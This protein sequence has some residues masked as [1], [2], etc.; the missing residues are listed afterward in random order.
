MCVQL[1]DHFFMSV[2]W[3]AT[4]GFL[5][6][7]FWSPN[8]G[9]S[10]IL[11]GCSLLSGRGCGKEQTQKVWNSWSAPLT[12]RKLKSCD[13][14]QRSSHRGVWTIKVCS[15]N[16]K[17]AVFCTLDS[18]STHTTFFAIYL[19]A[20]VV[21]LHNHNLEMQESLHFV[22]DMTLHNSWSKSRGVSLAT[23]KSVLKPHGSR[24]CI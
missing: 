18:T 3:L 5:F 22:P 16:V 13:L 2:C 1:L 21:V 7:S 15:V 17:M 23:Y 14:P 9:M 24:L 12:P 6:I 4:W 8:S 11:E 20:E 19:W 10:Q